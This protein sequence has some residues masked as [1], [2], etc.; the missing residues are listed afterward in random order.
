MLRIPVGRLLWTDMGQDKWGRVLYMVVNP[1]I[2]CCCCGAAVFEWRSSDPEV[3][4]PGCG[5]R[6]C[7][8]RFLPCPKCGGMDYHTLRVVNN[9]NWCYDSVTGQ[10]IEYCDRRGT[11]VSMCGKSIEADIRSG[12][13]RLLSAKE[14]QDR[15]RMIVWTG[16]MDYA[17][18]KPMPQ[19]II[20]RFPYSAQ[21]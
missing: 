21:E 12:R 18:Q 1:P 10:V 2:V 5:C 20:D 14:S 16:S 17:P 13:L 4:C 3:I 8:K 19:E 15:K 7:K 6:I 11:A 9:N